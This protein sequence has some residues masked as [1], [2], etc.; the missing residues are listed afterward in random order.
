MQKTLTIL[1]REA[2]GDLEYIQAQILKL[3]KVDNEELEA[4][5]ALFA[6]CKMLTNQSEAVLAKVEVKND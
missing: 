5:L 1:A 2:S 3:Q 6:R 4:L